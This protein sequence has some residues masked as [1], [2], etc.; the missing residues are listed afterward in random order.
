MENA[1]FKIYIEALPFGAICTASH[2][3]PV[4]VCRGRM[5]SMGGGSEKTTTI[6]VGF[7]KYRFHAHLRTNVGMTYFL[8][9]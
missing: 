4:E 6:K 7:R 1:C 8:K 5:E 9:P 3:I 2:V